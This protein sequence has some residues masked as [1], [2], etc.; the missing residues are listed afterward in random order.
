MQHF[1]IRK[2]GKIPAPIKIKLALPPPPPQKTTTPPLKGGILWAWG[3]SSRK[4]PKMPGA[5]KIGAAISGSRIA[6]RNFMDITLFLKR[7]LEIA[8]AFSS[9]LISLKSYATCKSENKEIAKICQTPQQVGHTK[10]LGCKETEGR[11][12][13]R[14][15]ERERERDI[16]I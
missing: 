4:N 2:I 3:F 12:R 15:G 6:G 10:L 14:G 11:Y 5:H 16:Y 1:V 8:A 7:V 13:E 9:F